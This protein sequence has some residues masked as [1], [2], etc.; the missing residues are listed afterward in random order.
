MVPCRPEERN[1]GNN[2]FGGDQGFIMRLKSVFL[3]IAIISLISGCRISENHRIFKEG[4]IYQTTVES[5]SVFEYAAFIWQ[6]PRDYQEV[7]DLYPFEPYPAAQEYQQKIKEKSAMEFK[8]KGNIY[9]GWA[10]YIPIGSKLKISRVY[11]HIP[12]IDKCII[13][14]AEFLDGSISKKKVIFYGSFET[15]EGLKLIGSD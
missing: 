6:D 14:E 15:A 11:S 13:I 4:Q 12:R 8:G 10:V 2:D 5:F 9:G 7:G 1:A 3:S